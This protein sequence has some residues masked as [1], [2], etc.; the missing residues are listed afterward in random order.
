[1]LISRLEG[2]I[3]VILITNGIMKLLWNN[4]G[5]MNI[6]YKCTMERLYEQNIYMIEIG[7]MKIEII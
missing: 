1:M 2:I 5:I 4:V 7:C 6:F 3:L